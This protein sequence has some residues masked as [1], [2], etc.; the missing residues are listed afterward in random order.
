MINSYRQN[1]E[2]P[3][4][5]VMFSNKEDAQAAFEKVKN[6]FYNNQQYKVTQSTIVEPVL[7]IA[8]PPPTVDAKP[9]E[10]GMSLGF[11]LTS[12]CVIAFAFT[13]TRL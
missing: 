10:T 7:P 6:I 5:L 2:L 8:T 9:V 4:M 3:T 12:I 1:S 11:I 13:L